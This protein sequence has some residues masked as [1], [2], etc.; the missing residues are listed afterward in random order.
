MNAKKFLKLKD[1]R[2]TFYA[3]ENKY[4]GN[5][6]NAGEL[7]NIAYGYWGKTLGFSDEVLYYGGGFARLKT[8]GVLN[9]NI[10]NKLVTDKYYGDKPEDIVD[11]MKGIELYNMVHILGCGGGGIR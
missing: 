3:N 2:I 7:G 4:D 6:I 5:I 9:G 1:T 10:F 8:D 11:I